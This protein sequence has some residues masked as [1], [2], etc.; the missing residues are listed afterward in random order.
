M[1][2][3]A[4]LESLYMGNCIVG[5]NPILS[6][7]LN[8]QEIQFCISWGFVFFVRYFLNNRHKM[9]LL[10]LNSVYFF[11]LLDNFVVFYN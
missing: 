5:S 8:P 7:I 6:A 2:E 4:S 1:V 9:G 10:K 3:G 11:I